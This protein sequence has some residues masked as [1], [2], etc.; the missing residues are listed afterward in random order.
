[1][2]VKNLKAA[3]WA[4]IGLGQQQLMVNI[5]HFIFSPKISVVYS[6]DKKR[7]LSNQIH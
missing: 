1:M 3:Q 7:D 5:T 2:I 4:A 6:S